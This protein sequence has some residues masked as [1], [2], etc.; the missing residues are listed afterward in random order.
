MA[1]IETAARR[2]DAS[3]A[4]CAA[5][6]HSLDFCIPL[7]AAEARL[8]HLDDLLAV[9]MSQLNA[10]YGL[11]EAQIAISE[12]LNKRLREAA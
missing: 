7:P 6:R 5:L 3:I 12:E 4:A 11:V 9:V 2:L 8:D 10:A 1:P